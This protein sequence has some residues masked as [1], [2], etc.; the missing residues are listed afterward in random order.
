[1][2]WFAS[3]HASGS[4][5]SGRATLLHA[6]EAIVG[7][8]LEE[9]GR[10]R[11]GGD[12]GQHQRAP[13]RSRSCCDAFRRRVMVDIDP[14][15]TQFWQ[16]AGVARGER[17]GPR[18]LFHDRRA[19]RHAR[20]PDPHRRDRVARRSG[21]RS[22]STTGRVR[23]AGELDRFTTIASWRGPVRA[24][25]ARR[26]HI[27]PQGARVPQVDRRCRGARR[28]AFEIALDIHPGRRRAT[29]RPCASTVGG[30]STRG[31]GRRPRR[32]SRLRAG[33]GGRVLGRAGRLRR[34]RQRLVQ[35]SHHALPGLRAAGAR[36]GHRLRPRA[37]R[38]A[39][40]RRVPDAGGGG[41]GGRRHRRTVRGALRGRAPDRRG[42]L[43]RERVL[44]RF[45]EQAGI[46]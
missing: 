44:A 46:G 15:F 31:R 8:P 14:G 34:Y 42:A 43:R 21:H 32:L 28:R 12:A 10:C 2:S 41:R 23:E 26:A 13:R 1:M 6:G 19:D 11:A 20:L 33:L 4:G 7:P 24:D 16:D 25:R 39:R 36:P 29:S 17:R 35:R 45:C 30:S 37:C 40:A 5:S 27:W 3:R 38:S 18:R 9:L 22:C